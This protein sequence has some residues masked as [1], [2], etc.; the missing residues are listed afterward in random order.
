MASVV[1]DQPQLALDAD[2]LEGAG[3]S[4]LERGGP[5]GGADLEHPSPPEQIG[6]IKVGGETAIQIA[7]P[8]G[9]QG[10]VSP[11]V[12]GFSGGNAAD[13][14]LLLPRRSV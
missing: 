9:F 11:F 8:S 6:E 5:V 2:H 1:L 14:S 3:A 4:E 13:S 7:G 10:L 12:H